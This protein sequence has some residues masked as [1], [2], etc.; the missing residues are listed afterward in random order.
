MTK[1]TLSAFVL[2][3]LLAA[4][5]PSQPLK[6]DS[7]ESSIEFTAIGKPGFLRINGKDAKVTGTAEQDP[8][9]LHGT[10]TTKLDD[11]HTGIDMRDE[12]MKKK[13]LETEKFPT[14]TLK[15]TV[16]GGNLNDA[17]E[18][19]FKGTLSLHGI[20]KPV[21]GTAKLDPSSDKKSVK[22]DAKFPL[23][24]SDF[25]IDIPTYMGVTV[26][27]DVDVQAQFTAKE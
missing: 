25:K 24:L 11:F 26:A 27:E 12:H 19:P 15:W 16:A 18:V 4:A 2:P 22:V 5:A 20:E 14:A 3:L 23:K 21:E 1:F 9:G 8:A 17:K 10:F 13:Y 6:V 7:G